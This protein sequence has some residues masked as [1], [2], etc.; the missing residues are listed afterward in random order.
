[1]QSGRTAMRD[2]PGSAVRRSVRLWEGKHDERGAG[3]LRQGQLEL[4]T[5]DVKGLGQAIVFAASTST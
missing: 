3:N 4:P 2:P 5:G 1:V